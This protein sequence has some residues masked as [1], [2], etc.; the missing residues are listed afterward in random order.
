MLN[1]NTLNQLRALRLDG[2]VAALNDAA[3]VVAE[4]VRAHGHVIALVAQLF[5]NLCSHVGL[6]AVP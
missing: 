2:M 1:E 6:G 4:G 3:K 5:S